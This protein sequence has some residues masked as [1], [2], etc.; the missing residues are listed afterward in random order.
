MPQR[1]IAFWLEATLR[2]NVSSR[3]IVWANL[4][5]IGCSERLRHVSI[6]PRLVREKWQVC[7]QPKVLESPPPRW[8]LTHSITLVC[9]RRMLHWEYLVWRK[10]SM[11]L[12]L[13][14]RLAWQFICKTMWVATLM[15]QSWSIRWLSTLSWGMWRSWQKS[16]MTLILST[17]LCQK[18]ASLSKITMR[19][20]KRLKTSFSG[21]RHGYFALSWTKLSW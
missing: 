5:W 2:V 21:Y 10:L 17:L 14:R 7:L 16:T 4:P 3:S 9:P 13:S 18:I 19:W 12:K 15:W 6:M 1:Y 8:H 20:V 11:L